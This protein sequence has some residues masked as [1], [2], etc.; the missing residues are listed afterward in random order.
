MRNS[1]DKDT[2]LEQEMIDT[3]RNCR[4]P[5]PSVVTGLLLTALLNS[6]KPIASR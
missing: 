3:V 4:L 5:F 6:S 1:T 2:E